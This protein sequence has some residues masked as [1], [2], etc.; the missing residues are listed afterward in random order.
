MTEF[1]LEERFIQDFGREPNSLFIVFNFHQLPNKET[2]SAVLREYGQEEIEKLVEL[3]STVL[4]DYEKEE[5]AEEWLDLKMYVSRNTN[6][7]VRGFSCQ[8]RHRN[9]QEH[10]AT[11]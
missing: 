5:T 11:C 2:S 4:T 3:Y 9:H 8:Q 1:F 10:S 6:R 7:S